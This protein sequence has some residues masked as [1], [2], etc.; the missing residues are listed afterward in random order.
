MYSTTYEMSN[1]QRVHQMKMKVKTALI[2]LALVTLPLLLSCT[3]GEDSEAAAVTASPSAGEARTTA[4]DDTEIAEPRTRPRYIS[5]SSGAVHTCALRD[6]GAVVCWGAGTERIIDGSHPIHLGQ[7]NPPPDERFVAISS[8]FVHTCGLREDGKAVCWGAQGD[9][10]DHE[11]GQADPPQDERF[12]TISSGELHTCGLQEDGQ[13]VCWGD[14]ELGK[15][16][17]P[18]GVRFKSI[19]SGGSHTCGLRMDNT[20][21]CWGQ[22]PR[23]LVIGKHRGWQETPAGEFSVI[24]AAGSYT[25][26]LRS[27]GSPQC[28]GETSDVV[29]PGER[30][31][32]T[33]MQALS[34][35][36]LQGCGLREGGEPICWGYQMYDYTLDYR[37][38]DISTGG[39][40]HCAIRKDSGGLVCWTWLPGHSHYDHW[41]DKWEEDYV[42][43]ASPPGGERF[44]EQPRR[45]KLRLWEMMKS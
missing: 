30:P 25:C 1:C 21:L 22:E 37:F 42:G 28:W 45:L 3:A 12:V 24:E 26:G 5:V 2:L 39:G 18:E 8:G 13:A 38:I 36:G 9:E 17:P 27:N 44:K 4:P 20:V 29:D 7:S 10:A 15:S 14:D 33:E 19:A 35:G 34:V 6:D 23:E 11:K 32:S 16:T 40:H 43:Q 41:K 31:P